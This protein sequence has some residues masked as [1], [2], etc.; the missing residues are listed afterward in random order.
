M[1]E[2]TKPDFNSSLNGEILP[3]T[4]NDDLGTIIGGDILKFGVLS[5]EDDVFCGQPFPKLGIF[6]PTLTKNNDMFSIISR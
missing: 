6:D 4:R 3:D 5:E 2:S 1:L